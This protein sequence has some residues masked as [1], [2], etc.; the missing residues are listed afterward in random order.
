MENGGG[1][2]SVYARVWLPQAAA[3]WQLGT[4]P[5][6]CPL[7]AV[8]RPK[9]VALGFPKQPLLGSCHRPKQVALGRPKEVSFGTPRAAIRQLL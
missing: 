6:S 1:V 2:E 8:H 7:A 4:I 9:E 5:S 3:S